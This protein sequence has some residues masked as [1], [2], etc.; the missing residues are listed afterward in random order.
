LPDN[1]NS[2]AAV[3]HDG[4]VY[5]AGG[6][7]GTRQDGVYYATFNADGSLGAWQTTTSLPGEREGLGLVQYNGYLFAIG[8]YSTAGVTGTVFSAPINKDGSVGAWVATTALPNARTVAGTASYN[9]YVYN[10][11]GLD[12]T[13]QVTDSVYHAL[14]S[15]YVPPVLPNVSANAVAGASTTVDVLNNATTNPDTTTLAIISGPTHGTARITAGKIVYTAQN[16]YV[17]GDSLVYQVCSLSDASVC[18]Q[19]TLSLNV[20]AAAPN[21]GVA[22]T[23]PLQSSTVL[24]LVTLLLGALGLAGAIRVLFK[25]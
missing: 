13:S 9:G 24:A 12:T 4:R 10:L 20:V 22:S 7:N 23:N 16:G 5:F 21:T 17:G 1:L 2:G 15:G 19:A 8:G 14:L 18:S 11:A 25:D 6:N 3:V